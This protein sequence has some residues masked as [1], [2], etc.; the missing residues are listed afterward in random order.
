MRGLPVCGECHK[1]LYWL[2]VYVDLAFGPI[3]KKSKTEY[4]H[5]RKMNRRRTAY[6]FILYF[7]FVITIAAFST[8]TT[9]GTIPALAIVILISM[10]FSFLLPFFVDYEAVY[11]P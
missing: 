7:L 1:R 10:V 2:E 8:F 4:R 11:I 3:Y 6:Q 5:C 9:M